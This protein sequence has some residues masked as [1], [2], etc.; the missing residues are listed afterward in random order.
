M[1]SNKKEV[2]RFYSVFFALI[3]LCAIAVAVIVHVS[4]TAKLD[5]QHAT[6]VTDDNI[7]KIALENNL[8]DN[9]YSSIDSL[10]AIDTHLGKLAITKDHAMQH[11]LLHDIAMCSSNLSVSMAHL[12]IVDDDIKYNLEHYINGLYSC[13]D[14]LGS[15]VASGKQLTVEHTALLAEMRTMTHSIY[16]T[17]NGMSIENGLMPITNSLYADGN[18]I[19]N[20]TI[21]AI[22]SDML[23]TACEH[24][25]E[26][27]EQ[28]AQCIELGK[29]ISIDEAKSM[30]KD[31]VSSYHG[32]D[33]DNVD[34][35]NAEGENTA[36][37]F[38]NVEA[39]GSSAYVILTK[40]GR[41]AQ[42]DTVTFAVGQPTKDTNLIAE[43]YCN[44]LG[45]NVTAIGM[46]RVEGDIQYLTLCPV[47]DEVTVYPD[48]IKV[49]VDITNGTVVSFNAMC[50]LANHRDR[51][52]QWGELTIDDMHSNICE[53][54]K[55]HATG[56]A[57]VERDG[58]E[59]SCC[60]LCL[61]MGKDMYL[62]HV[63][64]HTGEHVKL[65]HINGS[66][67]IIDR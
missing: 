21:G 65:A 51:Q 27:Y 8:S 38:V 66:N 45:Y 63:D 31:I 6:V 10:S 30:V 16:D 11:Q 17:L 36:F 15:Y 1:I 29:T 48:M 40:D 50:Y 26:H 61:G 24:L 22:D 43:Q 5:R 62:L 4:L 23:H 53:G 18:N 2:S 34:I 13:A 56:R 44:K 47:I 67:V 3:A 20:D 32:I 28:K 19:I 55:V 42:I 57:I 52:I 64:S 49:A 59:H 33:A 35:V 9:L 7:Y 54:A 46:P 39:K 58:V 25:D 12:P 41:V 14:N 37:Y 60:E